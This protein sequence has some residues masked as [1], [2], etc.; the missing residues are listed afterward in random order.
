LRVRWRHRWDLT[1]A[2]AR[3]AQTRGARRHSLVT[4]FDLKKFRRGGLLAVAD[5]A[6]DRTRDMC[7]AALVLWDVAGCRALRE[8]TNAAT[9]TFPYVPGLLSFREIPPLLP[10][11]RQ[12]D[13]NEID[14]ILCDG[15]GYAHPRRMGLAAHLG[16]LYDKPSLGWAKSWLIG[17]FREPADRAGAATKLIDKGEQI[18]WAFRSR[19]GVKI[20][21][22]SPGHRV[23]IEDSLKLARMLR[24]PY[25]LCEPARAAHH[26]TSMAMREYP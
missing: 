6:Y 10:L 17:D 3:A 19:P 9:S 2:Q 15:Q 1:P 21:F 23:S 16:I 25:R 5:V 18:G 12:I 22:I 4:G 11:F 7:F 14:L 20:S 24:G 26:L 8:W 13:E